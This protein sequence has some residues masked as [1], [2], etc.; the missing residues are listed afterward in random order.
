VFTSQYSLNF[1]CMQVFG[2]LVYVYAWERYYYY[3]PV[4]GFELRTMHLLSR[5]S[6][7][8][9]S[10]RDIILEMLKK[11]FLKFLKCLRMLKK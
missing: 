7:H 8:F 10:S 2:T 11:H 6:Y 4:L 3:F 9:T 1:R 5:R